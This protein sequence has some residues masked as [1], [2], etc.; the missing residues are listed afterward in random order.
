MALNNAG[1]LLADPDLA[2]MVCPL[3]C[4]EN[5]MGFAPANIMEHCP[6]IDQ[7]GRNKRITPGIF[8]GNIPYSPAMQDDFFTA[9]CLTQQIFRISIRLMWHDPVTF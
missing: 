1:N 3:L 7:H 9:P 2:Q 5:C 4:M 6:F 8:K